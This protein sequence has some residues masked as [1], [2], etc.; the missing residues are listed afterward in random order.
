MRVCVHS[1][2]DE[3]E[4]KGFRTHTGVVSRIAAVEP[5]VYA[6]ARAKTK[7]KRNIKH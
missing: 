1:E 4:I 6:A 7:L 2:N 3:R 5:P